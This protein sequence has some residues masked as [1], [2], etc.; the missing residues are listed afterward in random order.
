MVG[1]W[2]S[3]F[4]SILLCNEPALSLIVSILTLLVSLA[5]SIIV[6]RAQKALRETK[7]VDII[8]DFSN[9]LASLDPNY[10]AF[11]SKMNEE[12]MKAM[13]ERAYDRLM[14]MNQWIEIN[15][16]QFIM[17]RAEAVKVLNALEVALVAYYATNVTNENTLRTHII[18]AFHGILIRGKL[19]HWIDKDG[20][21]T[22]PCIAQ[23][24]K[25]NLKEIQKI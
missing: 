14:F 10:T 25:E 21:K 3:C 5:L 22:Y 11:F 15:K 12:Q 18:G 24:R 19:Y 4:W 7:A 9:A 6:Y 20:E 17:I 1:D 2:I 23:F 13:K 8:K 16:H